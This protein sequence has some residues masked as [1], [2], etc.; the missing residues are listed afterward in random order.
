VC[1]S[2]AAKAVLRRRN[3]VHPWVNDIGNSWAGRLK[4]E[5]SDALY[6]HLVKMTH[7]GASKIREMSSTYETVRRFGESLGCK[8][9]NVVACFGEYDFVGLWD[10][11]NE[12]AALKLAGCAVSNGTVQIQTLPALKIEDFFKVVSELPK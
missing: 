8:P 10:C 9:L 11:P 2:L 7:Q 5:V 1:F 3:T 12:V 4:K 6:A